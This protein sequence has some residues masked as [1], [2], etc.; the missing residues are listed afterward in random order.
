MTSAVLA[1]RGRVTRR[2]ELLPGLRLVRSELLKLRTRAGL[3]LA[4]LALT[5]GGVLVA[6][7]ILVVLHAVEPGTHGP[8][9]GLEHFRNGIYVLTQL[10]SIAAILIGATAGAGDLTTGFFRQLVITGRARLA[11]FAARIPGGLALLFPIAAAAYALTA[12]GSVV[13]AGSLPA[14]E[15]RYLAESGLWLLLYVSV[16]FLLALGTAALLGSR[17]TTIGLLAGLQLLVTPL[18]QGI[19]HAG[20]GAESI[21]G[22]ALWQLAP[23]ALQAG[24]P[25]SNLSMSLGAIVA[26]VV[27]WVAAALGFGAWRTVKRDA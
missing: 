1:Q 7:G 16:M 20:L 22:I 6:F 17:A 10:G 15:S 21:V 27:A 26:V 4:S 2:H 3:V 9:G 13:F 14:P 18:V 24:A 23:T 11:L 5:V 25:Q 8:A 12:A 19:N